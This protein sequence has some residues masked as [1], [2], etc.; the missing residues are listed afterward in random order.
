MKRTPHP[1]FLGKWTETGQAFERTMKARQCCY[2]C[3]GTMAYTVPAVL[4]E[5]RHEQSLS[6]GVELQAWLRPLL[7]R[8][9]GQLTVQQELG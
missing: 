6:T 2:I 4:R 3:Q 8:S 9:R 5:R 7:R 1:D